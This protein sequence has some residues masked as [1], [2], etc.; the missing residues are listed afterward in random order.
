V[1]FHPF[2]KKKFGMMIPRPSLR[3]SRSINTYMSKARAEIPCITL[4]RIRI[5]KSVIR[6]GRDSNLL[7]IE[8]SLIEIS[9][10][11]MLR[12]IPRNKTPWEKGNTT[13][14]MFGMEGISLVQEFPT[15]KGQSEYYAQ[16]PIRYNSRRHGKDL[17]NLG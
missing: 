13:N 3:P 15:Q 10:I 9:K 16:H 17:C 5:R 12:M 4:G 6:G 1:E 8:M 14:P 2:I 11:D 7:S